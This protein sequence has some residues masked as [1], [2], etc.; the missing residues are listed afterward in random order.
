MK[1]IRPAPYSNTDFQEDESIHIFRNAIN[2]KFIKTDI[3]SRDKYPNF[4]GYIEV[5]DENNVP[6][7]KFEVQVKTMD[8][9]L[10]TYYCDPRTVKYS[11]ITTLPILLILVKIKFKKV[12]WKHLIKENA[13]LTKKENSYKF[14]ISEDDEIINSS[15][16]IFKWATILFDYQKRILNYKKVE[17]MI[18]LNEF[19]IPPMNI[20]QKQIEFYQTFIDS[21]NSG[22]DTTF[23]F[24]KKY[25]FTNIWKLGVAIQK[26]RLGISFG[27][28]A[29]PSGKT[30]LL[31]KE[32]NPEKGI[33]LFSDSHG[34][35][36]FYSSVRD[37]YDPSELAKKF[38]IDYVKDIIE[39]R[40]FF[41]DNIEL[42]KEYVFSFIDRYNYMFGLTKSVSYNLIDIKNGFSYYFPLWIFSGSRYN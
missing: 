12:Y 15:N 7:G 35:F 30:D 25:Q 27:L 5:V 18:N 31:I 23:P 36:Q 3:K 40:P 26:D 4:D 34:F 32:V 19:T 9:S 38:L 6:Y 37:D 2:R 10:D 39:N 29:I 13:T 22:I 33:N 17:G 42:A 11:E 21:L 14:K 24:I 1:D 16:Y 20:D 28:F 41:F 8:D